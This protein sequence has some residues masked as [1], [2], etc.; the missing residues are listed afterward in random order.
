MSK[1]KGKITNCPHIDRP[2]LAKGM[3]RNCYYSQPKMLK[4]KYEHLKKRYS[5][6]PIYREK[7]KAKGRISSLKWFNKKCAEDPA[8]NAKKQKEYREKNPEKFNFLMAKSF[9]KK[10]TYEQKGILLDFLAKE[11]IREKEKT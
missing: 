8:W 5:S 9:S 4:R 1:S 6:D 3:C 11:R 7:M 2:V 10:L